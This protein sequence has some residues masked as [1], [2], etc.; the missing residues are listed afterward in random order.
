MQRL[1]LAL[2]VLTAGLL[3]QNGNTIMQ[4]FAGV[5]SGTCSMPMLARN[6]ATGALYNCTAA[7]TWNLVGAGGSGD[8][9]AAAN[10]GDGKLVVGSG[11]A[12]GIAASASTIGVVKL[13]AGVPSAA[14]STDLSDT[15]SIQRTAFT[16]TGTGASARTVD[17]KLKDSVSVKDFDVVGDGSHDDTAG[18]AAALAAH[19]HVRFPA[20]TYKL[21]STVTIPTGATIEGSGYDFSTPSGTRFVAAFGTPA[22]LITGTS[23]LIT[24]RNFFVDCASTASSTGLVIGGSVNTS[25]VDRIKVEDVTVRYCGDNILVQN[26]WGIHLSHVFSRDSLRYG[27]YIHPPSGGYT[28][29]V[30]ID[31]QSEF[32]NYN[33]S[34]GIFVD[35]ANEDIAIRNSIIQNN[36]AVEASFTGTANRLLID[37]CYFEGTGSYRNLDIAANYA[38]RITVSNNLFDH[39]TS[40]NLNGNKVA[41][42]GNYPEPRN[43]LYNLEAAL[44]DTSTVTSVSGANLIANGDF[45]SG[46]SWSFLPAS[47]S[48]WAIGSGTANATSVVGGN[49]IYQDITAATGSIYKVTYTITVSAGGVKASTG[50][51]PPAD[52]HTT[53]GTYTDYVVGVGGDTNIYIKG[54]LGFTGTVDNVTVY[55]VTPTPLMS[56]ST[57]VALTQMPTVTVPYGGSGLTTLTNHAV[58]VGAA[59]S[60]V[61]QVGPNAATTY[62]LF[63]AGSSADPA[64]RAIAAADLPGTLSSGTAI[65]NAALTTPSIGAATGTSLVATGIVSGLA[66]ITY[67][68][69]A[70]P[71]PTG[72]HCAVGATYQMGYIINGAT[73]EASA[74]F[75]DLPAAVAGQQYCFENGAG[76]S[77]ATTGVM[78]VIA[79]SGDYITLV[80]VKSAT[81]GSTATSG[82]AAG[83]A[84]CFIAIKGDEWI[85]KASKGTWTTN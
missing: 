79:A 83:D 14:A 84:A 59:T 48:G 52:M 31:G 9:T 74:T 12:K 54:Y 37:N 63:S 47:G 69:S 6:A 24:L 82:G 11:G 45:A 85:L 53:S 17:A 72:T 77:G 39:T 50:G 71:C 75:F 67:L 33:T 19:P 30:L 66:P 34:S 23:E 55:L 44:F 62:P 8:V 65:T 27:L 60:T 4:D 51:T 29:T 73:T 40:V 7:G 56:T 46:A 64:F 80:G 38:P 25:W 3:A 20:G 15:A 1:I 43:R 16:Q 35:G 22:F 76:D 61:T 10:I 68:Q 78:K 41:L 5:P 26:A 21:T 13:T 58:Q 49:S 57:A 32:G 70:D 2:L 28:T 36:G 18:I 81:S 42:L